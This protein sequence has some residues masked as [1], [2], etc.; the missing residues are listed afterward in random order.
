VIIGEK[1]SNEISEVYTALGSGIGLLYGIIS[2]IVALEL[3][4]GC[5]IGVVIDSIVYSNKKSK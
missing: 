4:F 5:G 1:N 3:I 2:S